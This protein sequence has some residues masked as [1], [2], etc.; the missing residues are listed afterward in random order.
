MRLTQSPAWLWK[1]QWF[2]MKSPQAALST[3]AAPSDHLWK[4]NATQMGS[5]CSA[6]W[7]ISSTERFCFSAKATRGRILFL[8][9]SCG[10]VCSCGCSLDDDLRRKELR[11]FYQILDPS[12]LLHFI[13]PAEQWANR[14]MTH[15]LQT[16]D[17][18]TYLL[19]VLTISSS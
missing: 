2:L 8:V 19:V 1:I 9:M 14:L 10:T 7:W 16:G 5:A 11:C 12:V 6:F 4:S 15:L 13:Q 18:H 3:A 17:D